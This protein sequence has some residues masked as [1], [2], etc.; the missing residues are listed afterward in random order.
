MESKRAAHKGGE[1]AGKA[2]KD[3]EQKTRKKVVSTENYLNIPQKRRKQLNE[4]E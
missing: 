4:K 3:L 1:V 2:R